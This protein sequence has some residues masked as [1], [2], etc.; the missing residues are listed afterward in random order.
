MTSKLLIKKRIKKFYFFL[1]QGVV[2]SVILVRISLGSR[3]INGSEGMTYV[4]VMT[5]QTNFSRLA[6]KHLLTLKMSV[7]LR[8]QAPSFPTC[9]APC[10]MTYK[11]FSDVLNSKLCLSS[12]L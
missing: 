12:L 3:F 11:I 9:P 4:L 2:H 8:L 1:M 7:P 10:F 5:V 6:V